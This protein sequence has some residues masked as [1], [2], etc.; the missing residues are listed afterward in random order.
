MMQKWSPRD[1]EISPPQKRGCP[2]GCTVWSHFLKPI[3]PKKSTFY[4]VVGNALLYNINLA[5]IENMIENN[6][7]EFIH[8][9]CTHDDT[10][11]LNS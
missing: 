3:I 4:I 2:F 10:Q 9:K 5:P 1:T 6:E 11:W 7:Y 8:T